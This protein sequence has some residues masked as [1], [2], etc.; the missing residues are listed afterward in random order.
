MPEVVENGKHREREYRHRGRTAQIPIYLGKQLRFFINESDWK[1]LPMAAVIA[2]LVSLVVRGKVFVNMEG[3]LMG[4]FAITCVAIWNGCFNSIQAVCRERAIIKREHRSGMHISSYVA[5][6][7]IYQFLLCLMQTVVSIYVMQLTDIGFERM[8]GF[9][10]PWMM[11]DIGISMLLVSY[12]ADMLSLLISSISRTTTGAMTVMPFILIF[13]LVFSGSL[14]PLPEWI[15]PLSNCTISTYGIR[16]IASQCAYNEL[17]LD[18]VWKTLNDMRDSELE[19]TVTV[20]RLLELTDSSIV[21]RY[22][23]ETIIP[24]VTAGEAAEFLNIRLP[25]ETDKDLILSDPVSLGEIL[26]LL[27][28]SEFVQANKDKGVTLKATMGELIDAFGEEKVKDFVM[29]K[30]ADAGYK[31]EYVRTNRNIISNWL[32]IGLFIVLFAVLSTVVLE[33]IDKDKR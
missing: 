6:H 15:Q 28:N 4:A 25:E 5:A 9:M 11:V 2:A 30:T 17:P 31:E 29:K 33:F 12:A 1:V 13:Q 19:E 26:D 7:M 20:G 32:M 27:A 14:I 3:T 10:T 24:A 23:E 22:R 18:T 21:S 16:A 8:A